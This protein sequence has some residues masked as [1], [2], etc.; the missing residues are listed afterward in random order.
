LLG[1]EAILTGIN[2]EVAQTLVQLGVDLGGLV[3]VGSLRGAVARA[4]KHRS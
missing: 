4:L 1:A 2:P 3:T